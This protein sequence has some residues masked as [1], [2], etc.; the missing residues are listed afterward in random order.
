MAALFSATGWATMRFSVALPLTSI[1]RRSQTRS[2]AS[3]LPMRRTRS[4]A[5]KLRLLRRNDSVD[6]LLG[7]RIAVCFGRQHHRAPKWDDADAQLVKAHQA[8]GINAI[9]GIDS[10]IELLAG[11]S[12]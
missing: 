6:H 10:V 7:I 3:R 5:P 4:R 11:C 12:L 2:A 8:T 9:V 1:C